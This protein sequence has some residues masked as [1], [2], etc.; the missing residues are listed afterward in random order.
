VLLEN[1]QASYVNVFYLIVSFRRQLWATLASFNLHKYC[2]PVS[3]L[4]RT[5]QIE[6]VASLIHCADNVLEMS[7]PNECLLTILGV[8]IGVVLL[9]SLE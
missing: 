5:M 9:Q 3:P 4:Y 7:H 2:V 6:K 8:S 1:K